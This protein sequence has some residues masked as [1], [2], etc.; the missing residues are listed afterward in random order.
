MI[1]LLKQ[2][3]DIW[4]RFIRQDEYKE[5]GLVRNGRKL[6]FLSKYRDILKPRVSEYLYEK[7]YNLTFPDDYKFGVCL[8]HDIDKISYPLNQRVEDFIS[9]KSIF[10]FF[11]NQYNNL[12]KIMK[13]EEKFDAISSFYFLTDSTRYKIEKL[14][15]EITNILDKGWE[16]GLHGGF[17]TFN[18]LEQMIEEKKNLE[19]IINK[20]IK[21]YRSHHLLFKTPDTWELLSKAGFK[22]DTTYGYPD[23][24]GFRNGMCHPFNP[25]NLTENK[26]INILE[27]PLNVM[28]VSLFNY[29]HLNLE[30]SWNFCKKIIDTVEK[31]GGIATFLWHNQAFSDKIDKK[32]WE[33]LYEKILSYCYKKKGWLTSGEEICKWRINKDG[34][35]LNRLL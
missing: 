14:E 6:F 21:G 10:K 29:M 17:Q 20:E 19:K 11:K 7:G 13:I 23:M 15:D 33:K 26:K 16:I 27:I 25:F 8:T 18:N 35:R 3:E 28:D 24:V 34:N 30:E 32:N 22:Y 1:E 31:L 5:I 9:H 4:E 2:N 12:D